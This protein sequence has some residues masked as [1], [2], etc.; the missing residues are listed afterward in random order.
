MENRSIKNRMNEKI[1]EIEQFIS[2]LYKFIPPNITLED[3]KNDLKTKAI[4]ERYSEK[5]IEAVEDLAFLI[6]N[7]NNL[8]YPENEKEIFDVLVKHNIISEKL[9]K[10][11]KD[12][13]GMRNIIAHEYGKID[14]EIVFEAA[15]EQLEK[16]INEFVKDIEEKLG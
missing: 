9:S 11:L 16:D 10:Q 3:Y 6:I 15:T 2:E 12:A 7:Y 4:C 13:K 5:I 1:E 8:K 14:D